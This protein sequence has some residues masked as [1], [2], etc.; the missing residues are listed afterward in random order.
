LAF[1]FIMKVGLCGLFSNDS[2]ELAGHR[3]ELFAI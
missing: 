3:V 1:F 2:K